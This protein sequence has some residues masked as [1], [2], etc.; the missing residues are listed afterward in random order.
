MFD[1]GLLLG[2]DGCRFPGQ[3]ID[4][5][6]FKDLDVVFWN[7]AFALQP[8]SPVDLSL[9]H[10]TG[11]DYPGDLG[12]FPET[13]SLKFDDLALVNFQPTTI[14]S[15]V[16]IG[17]LEDKAGIREQG[18]ELRN[19][20]M[21]R[22][23]S[24]LKPDLATNHVKAGVVTAPLRTPYSNAGGVGIGVTDSADVFETSDNFGL[25]FITRRITPFN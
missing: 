19:D 20:L 12:L 11:K 17:P 14:G 15:D 13:S 24:R 4:T 5:G 6:V 22:R 25:F 8:F 2:F 1:I 23:P 9:S 16:F 18:D 10:F 3:R 7:D 21:R